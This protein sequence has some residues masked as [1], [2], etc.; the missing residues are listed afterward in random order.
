MAGRCWRK[1]IPINKL[2]IRLDDLKI[3]L[4]G[5]LMP[6]FKAALLLS[7]E[8][9]LSKTMG[10]YWW[11]GITGGGE[12]SSPKGRPPSLKRH[13]QMVTTCCTSVIKLDAFGKILENKRT[14]FESD[15][16]KSLTYRS[17]CSRN[18]MLTK[19][20]NV[21][22][23]INWSLYHFF[24][25]DEI[26]FWLRLTVELVKDSSSLH[27]FTTIFSIWHFTVP[28]MLVNMWYG[29]DASVILLADKKKFKNKF[30]IPV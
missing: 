7:A 18:T 16:Q 11:T 29:L 21:V 6:S 27:S 20:K 9:K 22:A 12:L 10:K 26:I 24:L 15:K 25:V 13:M 5:M 19:Q 28:T 23:N 3:I 8:P 30:W 14:D 2:A 1:I 17:S 4:S